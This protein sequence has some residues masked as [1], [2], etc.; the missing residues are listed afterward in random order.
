MLA[1]PLAGEKRLL[2]GWEWLTLY[3]DSG[4][5]YLVQSSTNLVNWQDAAIL[6]PSGGMDELVQPMSGGSMFYRA[7]LLP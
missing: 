7:Q 6:V 5:R 2:D 4:R 3:G 1:A